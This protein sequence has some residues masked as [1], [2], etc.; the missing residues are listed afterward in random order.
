MFFSQYAYGTV[1]NPTGMAKCTKAQGSLDSYLNPVKKACTQ[2]DPEASIYKCNLCHKMFQGSQGLGGHMASSHREKDKEQGGKPAP[3]FGPAKPSPP[4][5]AAIHDAAFKKFTDEQQLSA[6][7]WEK[8]GRTKQ[9]ETILQMVTNAIEKAELR[10]EIIVIHSDDDSSTEPVIFVDDDI[11]GNVECNED[12]EKDVEG[13][14]DFEKEE[15]GMPTQP[16]LTLKQKITA[17]NFYH[18]NGEN[19]SSTCRWIVDTFKRLSVRDSY[20]ALQERN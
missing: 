13:N 20:S 5:V 7:P 11:E 6:T 2:V 9:A 12:S 17:L 14:E 16:R 1:L 10:N 18:A 19:K 3:K 8:L 15:I 4:E